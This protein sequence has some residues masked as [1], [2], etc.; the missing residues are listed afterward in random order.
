MR[1]KDFDYSVA[2]NRLSNLLDKG[3]DIMA[4]MLRNIGGEAPDLTY[5][6]HEVV[7]AWEMADKLRR[8]LDLF[9]D[10]VIQVD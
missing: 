8:E 2:L 7:R 4:K 6:E 9:Y 3:I 5:L 10:E 1:D